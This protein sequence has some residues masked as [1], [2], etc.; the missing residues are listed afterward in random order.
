MKA[1]DVSRLN[2]TYSNIKRSQ[3]SCD[4][5]KK[6]IE[7]NRSLLDQVGIYNFTSVLVIGCDVL[8]LLPSL[9]KISCFIVNFE[10][11]TGLPRP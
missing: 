1:T 2:K 5:D 9:I 6:F 7:R 10:E 11:E 4:F 8:I 3:C